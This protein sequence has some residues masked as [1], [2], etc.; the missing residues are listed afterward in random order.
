MILSKTTK[1]MSKAIVL[2]VLVFISGYLLRY[3]HIP[4]VMENKLLSLLQNEYVAGDNK[5]A[6]LNIALVTLKNTTLILQFTGIVVA[7]LALIGAKQL[8]NI[9]DI[10]G[11]MERQF[12][13]LQSE[14][15][16]FKDDVEAVKENFANE[17]NL[18]AAKLFYA[19]KFYDDAWQVLTR[20]GNVKNYEVFLYKGLVSLKK[21]DYSD[22][23]GY[24]QEALNFEKT[25]EARIHFNLG[26]CWH[27]S[28][29]YPSA[30]EEYNKTITAKA[31]YWGAYNNK[32]L[33]LKRMGKIEEAIDE[34]KKIINVDN[35]HESAH[36]NLACY[37]SI[38]DEKEEAFK[39]LKCAIALKDDYKEQ[40]LSDPDF[41]NIKKIK[42]FS[43]ITK[44]G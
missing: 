34:L 16:D 43:D 7:I 14:H 6:I 22:A 36:Y 37:Y 44:K 10:Q 18:V 23:M 9:K 28:K 41:A 39:H 17:H 35:K 12:R 38:I 4:L 13:Q 42:Q 31:N 19:Q 29:V 33:V 21:K 15:K 5:L 32:A 26:L 20:I 30:V 8:M 1:F 3:F 2:I 24:L 27:K 40:A 11:K 25:D